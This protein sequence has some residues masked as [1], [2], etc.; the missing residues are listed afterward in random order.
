[1]SKFNRFNIHNRIKNMV[2]NTSEDYNIG[3][4]IDGESSYT[5]TSNVTIAETEV[6]IAAGMSEQSA[7]DNSLYAAAH[8]GAHVKH[9]KTEP[10]IEL[11]QEGSKKGADID[12]LNGLVQ[13]TEDYR[14][15]YTI[16][17]E[18]PGYEDLRRNTMK[19]FIEAFGRN[20]SGNEIEDTTKAISAWTYG[21]DMRDLHG[22]W[23][24]LN[25]DIIED[26]GNIIMDVGK[27]IKSS[28]ES[29]DLANTLYDKHFNY[30]KSE[31][32]GGESTPEKGSDERCGSG[33]D[34][35]EGNKDGKNDADLGKSDEGSDSSDKSEALT[36]SEAED[37]VKKA[38]K[39]TTE[40]MLDKEGKIDLLGAKGKVTKSVRSEKNIEKELEENIKSLIG[41]CLWS[42]EKWDAITRK[43]CKEEH[44]GAKSLYVEAT[45]T[46]DIREVSI[47]T[48]KLEGKAKQ[49]AKKLEE[50]MRNA[51][52]DEAYITDNG[53][54]MGNRAYR[55][56][57]INDNHIF[58]KKTFDDVGGY[59]VD[60]LLDESGSQSCRNESI[61]EQAY[62]VTRA[63][64][65]AKI[66]CRV[67]SFSW[68]ACSINY[69]KRF[70]DY[71]DGM[72]KDINVF[73]FRAGGDNRDGLAIITIAYELEERPEDNKILIVLS[74]GEPAA[75]SPL[76]KSAGGLGANYSYC[77]YPWKGKDTSGV[78]D[79]AKCIRDVRSKGIALLGIYVGGVGSLED[80][81]LMYGNDFA[82]ITSMKT[83]VPKVAEYLHKQIMKFQ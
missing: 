74:D 20:R 56:S 53:N 67:T 2:W 14:V 24:E 50:D 16:T 27:T 68:R 45:G 49:L 61:R 80:E 40:R 78:L 51:K 33:I 9:S 6:L 19:G 11:L 34:N 28:K 7:L 35:S 39:G 10:L 71:D 23:N 8:E 13:A 4:K 12:I 46:W 5:D 64:S 81:K 65:L 42:K 41:K 44:A 18:R 22:S 38:I 48:S 57:K 79:T 59:V 75:H 37:L 60:L 55:A 3:I 76:V 54:V 70:R 32:E 66:P 15:D 47:I 83:F 25:W 30:H 73:K 26:A 1:M 72:E 69:I 17:T 21:I 52:E 77:K 62:I 63:C 58:S 36:M 82:Y 31:D 29:A 43:T